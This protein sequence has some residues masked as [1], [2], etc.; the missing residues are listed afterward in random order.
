MQDDYWHST[1]LRLR[2]FA[3]EIDDGA[4]M[5]VSGVISTG[6]A[7][8]REYGYGKLLIT[9]KSVDLGRLASGGIPLLDSQRID[10][11]GSAL[12]KVISAIAR[13]GVLPGVLAF[14]QTSAGRAAFAMV[15]R[16]EVNAM[17]PGYRVD[18]WEIRDAAG[19]VV[20]PEREYGRWGDDD[21]TFT[22]V[23]WE[24]LEVSLTLVP[25]DSDAVI[26][27]DD[28]AFLTAPTDPH[29][30]LRARMAAR[31]RMLLRD[32]GLKSKGALA[33]QTLSNWHGPTIFNQGRDDDVRMACRE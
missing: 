10:S 2:D 9:P 17:S 31:T 23:R 24:L 7:V 33:G 18:T 3:G 22:A 32:C 29:Y 14:N 11:V 30:D 25:Q 27:A 28:R 1:K 13:D 15:Q 6:N 5:M 26:S 4:T 20:D 19:N 8:R 12:G 16:G 21:L